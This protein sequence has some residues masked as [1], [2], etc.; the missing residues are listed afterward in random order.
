MPENS[1]DDRI[2]DQYETL[3][4]DLHEPDAID[5]VVSFLADLAGPG[6]ALELG[7]GTGRI[8]LPLAR[9]GVPV[10]GIE[11]SPAMVDRL[12]AR[13]GGNDV[14]VTIGDFATTPVDSTFTL[15][16]L[17]RNTIT[18]LT[19]QDEQVECFRNV[20]AHSVWEKPAS[21]R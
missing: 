18:N 19:S 4:P 14:T 3:W 1:F 21:H 16:Y 17:I 2:A 8:A 7:V 10:H 5:P 15:A 20:A 12:R 11:L 9:R 13:P 6:A